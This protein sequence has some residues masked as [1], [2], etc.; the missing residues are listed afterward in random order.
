MPPPTLEKH[1]TLRAYLAKEN[2]YDLQSI[3]SGPRRY[4]A[5]VVGG[6]LK[7]EGGLEAELLPGGAD[8][9]SVCHSSSSSNAYGFY[10]VQTG[11]HELY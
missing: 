7:S 9:M 4:I 1:F 3:R 8:W 5:A 10:D 6:F 2:I 11:T